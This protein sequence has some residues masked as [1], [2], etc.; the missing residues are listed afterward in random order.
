MGGSSESERSRQVGQRAVDLQ[1]LGNRR[2]TRRPD[3]VAVEHQLFQGAVDLQGLGDRGRTLVA[4][5]IVIET[6]TTG[7]RAQ[8][9]MSVKKRSGDGQRLGKRALT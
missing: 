2:G 7:K 4:D 9:Q 6:A 8:C 5:L 1:G 3:A